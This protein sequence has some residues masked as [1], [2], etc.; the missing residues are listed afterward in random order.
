MVVAT[1]AASCSTSPAVRSVEAN[2]V[3]SVDEPGSQP[4]PDTQPP[5]DSA[6]LDTTPLDTTAPGAVDDTALDW[7]RCD[8]VDDGLGLQIDCATLPVPLDHGA[9][10]G[11]TIDIELARAATADP[12]ERIGSL[13]FNP[14]G[15][16]GSGIDFLTA[17][18]TIVPP[19]L[20]DR[21]DLVSFDPRGVGASTAV[22]CDVD[23]DDNVSLLTAGDDDGWAVLVAEALGLP[24]DCTAETADLAPYV[25]TNSAARDLDLIRQ[26]LGDDQLSYVGFSYG[27]RLGATYAELFPERVRALVLDGAVK[28][29]DDLAQ[30]GL[31]QGPGFDAALQSFAA[32]CD[33]DA[34]CP[35]GT[36]DIASTLEVYAGL[37]EEIAEVG[38]FPTDDGDRVLTP[39]E[40]QLGVVAALYST[41]LWPVLADAL[42]IADTQ[43]DGSLLAAL[44]DSY[45]GRQFDGTYDNSQ[46]AGLAI[47]CADDPRRPPI[48][49]V[50]RQSDVAAD[51][52]VYFGDF[53][54]ASTGCLGTPD[55]IDPIRIGPAEGS[56]P[57]LVI[58]TTGDPATP[59][60]WAVEMA[61]FLDAATLYTVEGD[62]HTAFLSIPCVDRVVIDYL[63]DLELPDDDAGCRADTI[64]ADDVFVP[65]GTGEFDQLVAL[66]DCLRDVG[67]DVPEI[68]VGDILA[69]PNGE[70]LLGGVDPSDPAFAA[71]LLA[72]QEFI[73][74]F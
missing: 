49:D 32:A 18:A 17:A 68:D 28:P 36:D 70:E 55:P 65:S 3:S 16:G 47:N 20:A 25:G 57:I 1:V 33:A 19:E 4:S 58:G 52:S 67:V 37:V 62:G 44:A 60:E 34:D 39:G 42:F 61:A 54:R 41:Q 10:D 24:D 5:A 22:E 9:P 12:D 71:A 50:R 14:G 66:F 40:L 38:S 35:L 63:V 64:G 45:L 7:G 29:T 21:F 6:P 43:Q 11:A 73:P 56:A 8:G 26:A 72:C 74:G 51:S 13:V 15:P 31:E 2:E 23:V 30:I 53:L 69:D 46:V 48:D 59:Y 27:T